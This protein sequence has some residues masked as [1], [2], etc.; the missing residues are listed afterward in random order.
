MKKTAITLILIQL[1]GCAS[2]SDEYRPMVDSAVGTQNYERDVVQC[3]AYAKQQVSAENAAVVG[4]VLGGIFGLL[5][6]RSNGGYKQ[7]SSIALGALA[8]GSG[9]AAG[10]ASS[11]R[12]TI[13]RCMQGRGYSVLN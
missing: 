7:N 4:A 9:A 5:F 12:E 10:E 11:Q 8:G 3:Q 6:A 13:K 2:V 1:A